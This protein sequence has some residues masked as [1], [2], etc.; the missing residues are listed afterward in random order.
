[1]KQLITMLMIVLS[2]FVSNAQDVITLKSGET[3]NAQVSEVG[4]NEIKYYKIDNLKGPLYVAAKSDVALV[5]YKNGSKDV[6]TSSA[7]N[8]PTVAQQPNTV[9]VERPVRRRNYWGSKWFYPLVTTHVDLGHHGGR[10]G[11]HYGGH[12]SDHD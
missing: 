2:A 12:H 5:V 4:I 3:I 1:M 11:G 10:Y 7:A 9:I 6:F 8:N